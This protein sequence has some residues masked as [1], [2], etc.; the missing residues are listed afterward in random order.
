[1]AKAVSTKV[2]KHLFTSES[3]TMGHPDKVSDMISDGVLDALLAKDPKARVACE[4]LV[5]TGL[6]VLAGEVTVHNQAAE[7]ALLNIEDVVRAT[8]KRIGYTNPEIGFDY[9]SCAVMRAIHSQSPDISQG[10][11]EGKGEHK[12]QGAGDQGIM[13]GF[14]CDETKA[15]MP[16][17]IYLSHRMTEQLTKV[18]EDGSL[19]WVLP[20]G[21]TQVTVEYHDEVPARIHTVVVSTQH[22]EG[23][24]DKD[25]NMTAKAR[26]Q[27]KDLVIKRLVTTEE[28]ASRAST[29]AL[30][31]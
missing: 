10:V 13:F 8:I 31:G 18:R 17:P 4:T 24:V 9:R 15:L 26:K 22:T 21:K 12:E 19:P 16:L 23:V 14:A 29:P 11:T 2:K 7:K 5:T 3:V 25:G 28:A 30:F 27:I 6:V 1:M 20:D